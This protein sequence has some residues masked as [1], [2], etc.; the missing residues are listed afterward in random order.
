MMLGTIKFYN[1]QKGFGFVTPDGAGVD[2]FVHV[3]ALAPEVAVVDLLPE[4]RVEFELAPSRPPRNGMQATRLRL[5]AVV[6]AALL[7]AAAAPARAQLPYYG[8]QAFSP[9]GE[10]PLAV[11]ATGATAA[12]GSAAPVAWVCNVGTAA[13]YVALG[14]DNSVVATVAGGFPVP[15]GTCAALYAAG[16]S[17]IAAITAGDATTLAVAT[18]TGKP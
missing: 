2:I 8:G 5:A 14:T 11:S 9:T 12:L 10:A 16:D 15:A 18:G 1:Q 4:A 17:Y 6:I 7:F 3:S 13:A